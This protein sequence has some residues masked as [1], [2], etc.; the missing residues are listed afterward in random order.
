[1]ELKNRHIVI[2]SQMQFDSRL[3]STN[4]TMAKHL[5]IDNYVYYV[6]RPYTWK[7]YISLKIRLGIRHANRTSFLPK[8]VLSKQRSLI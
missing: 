8:I 1:M 3:E 2:F 5:A 6:D 7:D 4:Y